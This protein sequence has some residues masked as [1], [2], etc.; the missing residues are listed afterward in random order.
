MGVERCSGGRL[1]LWRGFFILLDL[2]CISR[3]RSQ[4]PS[5][6]LSAQETL[7]PGGRL[8]PLRRRF[9]TEGFLSGPPEPLGETRFGQDRQPP[10]EGSGQL[11]PLGRR[12]P[13]GLEGPQ[14]LDEFAAGRA[15]L[16]MPGQ[17]LSWSLLALSRQVL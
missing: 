12:V 10:S 15:P 17:S 9:P 13:F 1:S 2:G 3:Q 5:L 11:R 7:E 6:R 8:T 4:R 16:E 14:G